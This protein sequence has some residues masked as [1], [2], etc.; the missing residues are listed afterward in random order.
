MSDRPVLVL[1]LAVLAGLLTATARS[2]ADNTL[3]I[4]ADDFGVDSL[5]LYGVGQNPPSTPNIDALAANGVRFDRAYACPSCSPTRASLL[6]GRYGFRTGIG[7]PVSGMS[8]GLAA[9]E[10]LLPERLATVGV[11]TGLFGKWHLGSDLGAQTPT[12]EGF[13]VFVG[14]LRGS[15]PSYSQWQK[16][17]N[18]S[19]MQSTAYVTTDTV[20]EAL[21]FIQ[22]QSGPWFAQLSFHA[23]HT[24]LHAPPASLHSQNLEGLDPSADPVPFHRAMIEAMDTEIG[25]LLAGLG[26]STLAAT[27]VVFVGD[28]GTAGVAVLPPFDPQRSKGS[29]FQGGIRVP[30]IVSGPAVGGST[31]RVEPSLAH[32]VDLFPT[33][34]TMQGAP[35]AAEDGVDLSEHLQA[36]SAPAARRFAFSEAF[37]GATGMAMPGDGEVILDEHYSLVRNVR[38]N[39]S[40]RER[41][42]DLLADPL[43]LDDLLQQPLAPGAAAAYFELSRELARLRGYA[44]T[45]EFGSGCGP[46]GG[47]VVPDLTAVGSPM[48]G[49]AFTLQVDALAPTVL[50]TVGAMGFRDDEWSGAPLPIDLSPAGLL[51]CELWI[52]P[53]VTAVAT[54]APGSA[55]WSVSFPSDPT[56]TGR[57]IFAQAFPL[58]PGANPAGLLASNAVVGVLGS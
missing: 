16:I 38:P 22:Q 37:A 23:P 2:Q 40:V 34:L 5:G 53:V 7:A 57:E 18:G 15:V 20:D 12:A 8:G 33:L 29:L 6:T 54:P 1:L 58:T 44:W 32:V 36:S 45:A 17:E 10:D 3:L 27:N 46:V 13:D 56:L 50:V 31:P 24:P 4:V 41:M 19:T 47:G 49:S 51:G 21:A 39:G 35:S 30:L 25:R 11:A 42:F 14:T 52:A 28:N 26:T 48:L 55:A 43:E 9:S